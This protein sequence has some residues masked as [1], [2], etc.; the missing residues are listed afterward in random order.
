M[1]VCI[2]PPEYRLGLRR[3]EHYVFRTQPEGSRAGRATSTSPSTGCGS[4]AG[5]RSRELSERFG[6]DTKYAMHALRIAHQGT[7]LLTE[8]R[9]SMPVAEPARS[10]L[11]EVRAGEVPLAAVLERLDV[12]TARLVRACERPQLRERPD[13]AAVEAFLV[14]AYR[15]AWASGLTG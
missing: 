13:E 9:I 14:R 5:W 12:A 15:A 6:Y 4:S 10:A 8:G 2:E 1:G 11:R 3:F 7:A